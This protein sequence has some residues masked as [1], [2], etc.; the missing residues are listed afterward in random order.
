MTGSGHTKL[1]IDYL[2]IMLLLCYNCHFASNMLN[3][4][5]SMF[6]SDYG[7]NNTNGVCSGFYHTYDVTFIVKI[8]SRKPTNGSKYNTTTTMVV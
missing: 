6:H 8:P 1:Y 7:A 3:D 5:T 2:P 4:T